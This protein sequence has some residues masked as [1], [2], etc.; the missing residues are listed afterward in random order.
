MLEKAF[1]DAFKLSHTR[2]DL[3]R[4][5]LAPGSEDPS[6]GGNFI[7]GS[8]VKSHHGPIRYLALSSWTLSDGVFIKVSGPSSRLKDSR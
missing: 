1:R 2:Q 8:L 7:Y 4:V 6:F 5:P 3:I